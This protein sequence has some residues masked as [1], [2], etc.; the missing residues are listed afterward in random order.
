MRGR[1][2]GYFKDA[3]R[4]RHRRRTALRSAH[5]SAAP[6]S[7]GADGGFL[8]PRCAIREEPG[9]PLAYGHL[10]RHPL[11]PVTL[12]ARVPSLPG[13][14]EQN[15]AR[16]RCALP[17]TGAARAVRRAGSLPL[18]VVVDLLR[19]RLPAPRCLFRRERLFL[20]ARLFLLG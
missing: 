6:A 4:E 1:S 3:D 14:K 18:F 20:V 17:R 2:D 10:P 11:R 16:E 19:A 7:G 8:R 12:R 5:G 9:A 15:F 13:K